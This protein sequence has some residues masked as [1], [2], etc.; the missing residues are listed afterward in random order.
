MS[1]DVRLSMNWCTENAPDPPLRASRFAMGLIIYAGILAAFI[2][3]IRDAR[4]QPYIPEPCQEE[5]GLEGPDWTAIAFLNIIPFICATFALLRAFV[6]CVLVR[7]GKSLGIFSTGTFAVPW[8]PCAP[9]LGI[10]FVVVFVVVVALYLLFECVR[11]PAALIMGRW[12]AS[13]WTAEFA[14]G[15]ENGNVDEE[16]RGEEGMGLVQNADGGENADGEGSEEPPA[17]DEAVESKVRGG[18]EGKE[19]V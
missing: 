4:D 5:I 19:D 15:S 9:V 8:P 14:R 13:I 12:E 11:I 6:D 2:V 16:R 17:Y 3:R 1:K 10:L 18:N 7:W